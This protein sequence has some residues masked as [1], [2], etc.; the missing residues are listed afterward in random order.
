ME[1]VIILPNMKDS[2]YILTLCMIHIIEIDWN[3]VLHADM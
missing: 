1:N 3:Y 2:N